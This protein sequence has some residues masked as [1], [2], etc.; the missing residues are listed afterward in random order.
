MPSCLLMLPSATSMRPC[1][2]SRPAYAPDDVREGARVGRRG[3]SCCSSGGGEQGTRDLQ[4]AEPGGDVV[5]ARGG[6]RDGL[7]DDNVDMAD[8]APEAAISVR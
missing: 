5:D 8:L 4:G 7:V 3:P 2:A 1:G 6:L